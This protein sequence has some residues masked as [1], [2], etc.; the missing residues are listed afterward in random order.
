MGKLVAL[1]KREP[2]RVYCY[3]VGTALEAYLVSRGIISGHD[4]PYVVAILQAVLLVPAVE[5]SRA[6][7]SP[8]APGE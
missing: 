5:A 4:G 6:K 3:G 1:V 8:V 7:V 2:V